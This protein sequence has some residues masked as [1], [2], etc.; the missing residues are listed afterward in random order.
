MLYFQ[1]IAIVYGRCSTSES[2]TINAVFAIT[3][4]N[5]GGCVKPT[6]RNFVRCNNG[7]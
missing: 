6:D 7:G 3:N 5:R 1:F 4:A 2:V